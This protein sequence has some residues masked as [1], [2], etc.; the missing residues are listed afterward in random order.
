M[1]YHFRVH[2]GSP[3]WAECVEL[4]GCATQGRTVAEL[5]KNMKQALN[6]YLL[7]PDSSKVLFPPPVRLVDGSDIVPVQVDPHIAFAV[8]LRLLRLQ[9]RLTQKEAAKRLGMKNIYSYQR[10]ERRANPSLSTMRRVLELFPGMSLDSVIETR[11]GAGPG[12]TR[13]SRR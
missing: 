1:T 6:L 7:E 10:L 3:L 12:L 13:K 5:R 11:Q 4:D 8:Q 2:S 9:A